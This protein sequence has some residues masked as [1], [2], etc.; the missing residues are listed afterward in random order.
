[1]TSCLAPEK[2][3]LCQSGTVLREFDHVM[4]QSRDSSLTRAAL[5]HMTRAAH[6]EAHRHAVAYI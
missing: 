4:Q 2:T 3:G 1:M 5:R 6:F